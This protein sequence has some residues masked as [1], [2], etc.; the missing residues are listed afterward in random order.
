MLCKYRITDDGKIFRNEDF[1][2]LLG[3]F[4]NQNPVVVPSLMEAEPNDAMVDV[5]LDMIYKAREA[6]KQ[7]NWVPA[8]QG[9]RPGAGIIAGY[10]LKLAQSNFLQKHGSV[11]Y[12]ARISIARDFRTRMEEVVGGGAVC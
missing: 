2:V 8:P 4:Y 10:L 11:M 12:M 5:L 1:K 6:T 9:F 7:L 3:F